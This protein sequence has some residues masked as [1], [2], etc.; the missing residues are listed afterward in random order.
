MYIGL[1]VQVPFIPVILLTNLEFSQQT[2]GTPQIS[3]FIKIRLVGA[4]LFHADR[5][6]DITKLTVTFRNMGSYEHI[7]FQFT[8][9]PCTVFRCNYTYYIRTVLQTRHAHIPTP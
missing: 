5:R 1:H 9:V 2:S 8:A 3:N 6:T 4:E 7:T